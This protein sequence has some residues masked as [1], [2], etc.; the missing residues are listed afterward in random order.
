MKKSA[1]NGAVSLEVVEHVAK[2]ARLNL[3]E[4]EK[5]KYRKDLNEIVAAF[6]G[7]KSVKTNAPPSFHPL[8]VKDVYRDDEPEKCLKREEALRNTK[9]KEDGFF[10]GPRAV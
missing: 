2:I 7:I 1:K 10:K 3:S 8:D 6:K 4:G 5:K 9:H